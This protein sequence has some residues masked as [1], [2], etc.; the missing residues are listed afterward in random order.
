[1]SY[2]LVVFDPAAPPPDHKG[3][4]AWY[5]QQ[6]KW[7]EGH[8]YDDP[9]V[10][11]PA[12]R[13]WFLDMIKTYPIPNGPHGIPDDGSAQSSDYS[14]GAVMIYGAFAWSEMEGAYQAAFGLAKKHQLG[15]F[16]ASVEDGQVWR[17]QPG[18][19]YACVSG[20]GISIRKLGKARV[21]ILQGD[22]P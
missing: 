22:G 17:P 19:A 15:F 2:D 21:R 9:Q 11:S 3:F 12:L 18:G 10:S 5:Q 6:G 7:Q 8:G 13:A 16:D 14:V 20:K 1:M 4:L